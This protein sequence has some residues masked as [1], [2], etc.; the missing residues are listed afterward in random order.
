LRPEIHMSLPLSEAQRGFEAMMN[1]DV[2]GKIV[3]T[4]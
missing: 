2:Y 4:T 3:F 1:G